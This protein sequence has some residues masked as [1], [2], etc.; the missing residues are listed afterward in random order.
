MRVG[1]T[2]G[3]TG[4]GPWHP[5]CGRG[6]TIPGISRTS[7]PFPEVRALRHVRR[8]AM[9]QGL[10]RRPSEALFG[11]ESRNDEQL[12]TMGTA[13]NVVLSAHWALHGLLTELGLRPGA[14]LGHS[15]GE[16]LSLAAAG[17][18]DID[19]RC[20]DRFGE[21]GTLFERQEDAG[22]VPAAALV[23]VAAD[24]DRVESICRDAGLSLR[25]AM[26][27]CP[28]QVVL[29][30]AGSR[31]KTRRP[32]SGNGDPVRGSFAGPT[33]RTICA[34]LGRFGLSSR[35]P[36]HHP[37][38]HLL[39]CVRGLM[40]NCRA[41]PQARRRA[42]VKPVAFRSTIESMY[43]NGVRIFVELERGSLTGFVGT[44]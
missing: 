44:R 39:M 28:R 6:L 8:L 41:D 17:V 23:A 9:E 26:D 24:R 40:G 15:S 38:F 2:S 43:A 11:P 10:A 3:E 14:V 33:T 25:I 7:V 16:F 18:F 31:G 36:F 27:N 4:A 19:S 22:E 34:A 29:S 42:V 32:A 13:V 1:R 21:L 20:E 35:T 12:W 5:L 30:G 37:Q